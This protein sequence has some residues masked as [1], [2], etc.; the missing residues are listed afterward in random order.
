MPDAKVFL[1]MGSHSEKEYVEKTAAKFDGTILGAN[2][3]EATPGASASFL[4]SHMNCYAI[5]PMTYAF[6]AYVDPE[7]ATVRYDLDWIK[8][9]QKI[10]GSNGKTKRD[11]KS[12]YAKLADAFGPPFSTAIERGKAVTADDFKNETDLENIC[13]SVLDYQMYRVRRELESDEEAKT[14]AD[15]T[16]PPAFLY[17]PYFYIEPNN[18]DAWI[19]LNSRLAATAMRLKTTVPV[20][21]VVCCHREI[22]SDDRLRAAILQYVKACGADGVWLWISRFDEHTAKPYELANLRN[23][24]AGIAETSAVYNMHGGFYSLALSHYGMSGIAH[25]IGYGEQKDVVPIIGQSTPTVQYYVRPLHA[26]FSVPEI[27]RCF[28]VLG[29]KDAADFYEKICDC[30][31]CKG[32]IKDDLGAFAQFGEI[33][34]STP[35][36]KRAAQTPAAAKRCRFHFLFNRALERDAVNQS[37]IASLRQALTDSL[38]SWEQTVLGRRNQL[39]FLKTW[40]DTLA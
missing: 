4:A 29:I 30:V 33:H 2:L 32:V 23:F 13:R 20:H 27:T 15:D 16:P 26:K 37:D 21:V 9:D 22:L 35:T 5:D 25:G 34:F 10:R 12:S 3:V 7:T 38:Q 36:S 31:I 14:F 11:F 6:G 19:G 1:R 28:S 17:A 8:S 39:D 40:S 18:T 24:V